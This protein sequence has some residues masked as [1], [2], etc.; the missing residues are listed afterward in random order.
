MRHCDVFVMVTYL[1]DIVLGREV[2]P[3]PPKVEGDWGQR[4]DF[5]ALDE[6]LREKVNKWK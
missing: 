5:R 1:D 3:D 2:K 4:W 6:V